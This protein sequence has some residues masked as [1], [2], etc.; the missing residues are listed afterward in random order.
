MKKSNTNFNWPLLATILCLLGYGLAALYSASTVESFQKY[1]NATYFIYHQ[2]L[3]GGILG[4]IALFVMSKINY[5]VWQ[6]NLPLILVGS[7]L[8]LAMVKLSHLGFGSGGAERWLQLGP[9]SFQ[10]SELAKLAVIFYIASWIEKKRHKL[11]DFYYGV[12]PSLVIIALFAGL[13]LWQPDFG[14]MLVLVGV[15]FGMLFI[16]GIHI[17]T[18]SIIALTGLVAVALFVKFEPYRAQRITSFLNPQVDTQK[19]G[20]QVNQAMLAVGSGEM[21]GYGYGLSRQK[22]NYLPEAKNDSVFAVTAEEMGFFRVV[23]I[24]FLFGLLTVQGFKISNKAP[25]IFGKL[26]AGG[27]TLWLALQAIINIGA[28]LSLLPLTGIPLPLFSYGSTALLINLAALG[29]L[30]NISRQSA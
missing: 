26:T 5:H 1:G 30:L 9:L 8:L 15:A 2:M 22:H 25:D 16:S 23:L 11:D 27:I 17:K 3:Y 6:K 13:I 14:T 12:L 24:I 20:Y 10:P 21:W 19:S 4:L 7:I 18:L 29:I 28:I